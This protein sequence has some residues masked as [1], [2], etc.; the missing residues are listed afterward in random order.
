MREIC[1]SD[2]KQPIFH[3]L[4]LGFRV[5]VNVTFKIHI[6][7]KANFSVFRYQHVGIPNTKFIGV[8]TQ[9][10]NANVF[11]SQWNIGIRHVLPSHSGSNQ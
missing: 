5:G 8:V 9:G 2:P 3:W 7:G 11:A 1:V 4:A 10:T 6:G